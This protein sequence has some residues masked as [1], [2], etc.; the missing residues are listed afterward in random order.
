MRAMRLCQEGIIAQPACSRPTA[1][2]EVSGVGV[3][4]AAQAQSVC[5]GSR[6]GRGGLAAIACIA[7]AAG[8]RTGVAGARVRMLADVGV[9]QLQTLF[10]QHFAQLR[11]A[12]F[13]R[14]ADVG[15]G[16]G[17]AGVDAVAI[18]LQA[19]FHRTQVVRGH[20][21]VGVAD[22]LFGQPADAGAD[23]FVEIRRMSGDW[24]G[25]FAGV[26]RQGSRGL[27]I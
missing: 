1:E 19:Y 8:M 4:Q 15:M 21:D 16:A 14:L 23:G 9:G 3:E 18:Q 10:A 20:A 6:H 17:E 5:G 7:R 13:Q 22:L 2:E 11:Q 24:R 27:T 12:V 26:G 25:Q